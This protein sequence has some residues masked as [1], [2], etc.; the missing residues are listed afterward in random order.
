MTMTLSKIN[1]QHLTRKACVYIRQSTLTQVRFN[2]ESTERQY[3]LINK[4]KAF[5]WSQDQ[6][7]VLDGDLGQSGSSA[8]QRTDFKT[9]VSEVALGQVGAIFSLEAS[10]LA[11]SNQ[12]WHRLLELCAITHTLVVDEDGCYN[13]AEFND[14]LVLGMKGAFA[15]AE[16]HIIRGRL[17][18][19]KLNKANKGELRFPLPVGFVFEADKIVLDPDQEVQGAVRMIFALFQETGSAFGVT[20]RFNELG[21][22]FPRRSYGGAWDGKLVWGPLVHSRVTSILLNPS[23]AGVYVFGRYQS[24]KEV[25]PAGEIRVKSRRTPQDAWRVMIP[26]HHEGYIDW[27]QYL[28]NGARLNANRTNL[29]VLPGPA[30][31]GLCLL[32]GMLVCGCCGRRVSVRYT[33]NG[34]VYPMYL[35]GSR[36]RR[37]G[38]KKGCNLNLPA[39]PID[40]TFSERLAGAITPM[41]IELALAALTA[42]EDRDQAIGAQWR[43]RIDRARYDAELA[44]RRYEAVDPTN[45]LIAA[46]LEQRWNEALQRLSDLKAELST[47]E[48]QS[49]RAVTAEQKHQI[50]SLVKDFPRLWSSPTTTSKDRKRILRLLVQD[51][52]VSKGPEPKIVNLHIRWQGGENETIQVRLPKNQADVLRYPTEFVDRVRTLALCHPDGEI[53]QLMTAEGRQSSTGKRLTIA[54]I[55]WIRWKHRIPAPTPAPGAFSVRNI[56][57][58]YGVS[59]HVVYYWID[60]G[61]VTAQQRKE[62]R[63]YEIMLDDAT[64]QRLQDWVATSYH[65]TP[66]GPRTLDG[67][68]PR[69]MSPVV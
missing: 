14:S 54:M 19:G 36:R 2:Q 58:R 53:A 8:G 61:V 49:M 34:G 33:G 10:R 30:R 41:R 31:E 52:I 11:R 67:V 56:A 5:G 28:A 68:H 66:K 63:P 64:D 55:R 12:D 65:M 25:G 24:S 4:A 42:L 6:I 37:D 62:N 47:F 45:R 43:M 1:P 17:H 15:Q 46:T 3:N 16:L 13:P 38:L 22:R 51:V 60:R 29:D 18:G 9:L 48:K 50:M 23:Y 69:E 26:D 21:L 59:P 35:C 20:G 7:Q 32:Q 44:E 39:G 27:D 57:E 40:T